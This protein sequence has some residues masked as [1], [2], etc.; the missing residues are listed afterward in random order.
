MTYR[1]AVNG[2]GRIGRGYL[3][4]LL[5]RNLFDEGLEVVAVNDLWDAPTLAHLLEFDSTFG[6]LRR[7]VAL[8]DDA[9]VVD[10]HRIALLAQ[11]DREP[12]RGQ[13]SAWT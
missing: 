4:C 5:E 9:I 3:R 11:R 6:P 12:C 2:F 13:S 1:I 8:A 7:S 10:G